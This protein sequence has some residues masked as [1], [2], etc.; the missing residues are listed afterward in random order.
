MSRTGAIFFSL[1]LCFLACPMR[2]QVQVVED[3]SKSMTSN[4]QTIDASNVTAKAPSVSVVGDTL[5]FSASV[6]RLAEDA[7]LED[8]L[9]KIPGIEVNGNVV[10][11]Y[12]KQIS[13]LRVN[14]KRYFG[15]DVASGLQ[16]LP[17]DMIDRVGAY[18]R[19]SD[20]ARLTGVDDGELVPVLDVK[21]KQDFLE[22][23]KGRLTAGGGDKMRYVVKANGNK[24]GE[25]EQSSVVANLHNLPGKASFNNASRTQ[26]GGGGSGESSRREAGYSYAMKSKDK[27]LDW[28]IRYEGRHSDVQSQVQTQNVN[29][30]TISYANANNSSFVINDS[31]KASMRYMWK[32][33]SQTTVVLKPAL[34]YQRTDTWTHNFADNFRSDPYGLDPDSKELIRASSADN[35][36]KGFTGRING[37]MSA[38]WTR[39]FKKRGR[40]LSFQ[41]DGSFMLQGLD[42]GT[43]YRT[44]YNRTKLPVDTTRRQYIDQDTKDWAFSLQAAWSEPVAKGLFLQFMVRGEYKDR[45]E[46]RRLYDITKADNFWEVLNTH[47]VSEFQASLPDD[48]SLCYQDAVSYMGRY[49]YYALV[50]NLNLRYAKKRFNV[51]AGLRV[52]PAMQEILWPQGGENK[53]IKTDVCYLAPNLTLNYNPTKRRKLTAS[54]RS[55]L[56]QP[57][58]YTLLPVSNGTNPL[59][60]HVGNPEVKPSNTHTFNIA[61]NASSF[62]RKSS[63]TGDV[64]LRLTENAVCNSTEYDEETGAKTITPRNIDGNWYAQGH[65]VL[66]K[67]FS[68][69]DFS[70][71]AHTSARYDNNCNYLYNKVARM[72]ETNIITRAMLKESLRTNYRNFWL[73]ITLDLGGD[74]TVEHSLL[75]PDLDQ[76]PWSLVASLSTAVSAPWGMRFTADYTRIMQR[77]F[78]YGDFN[79]SYDVLNGG[80][81]QSFLKKKLVV[82]LEACDILGQLPNL[83]RRYS[84]ESRSVSLFN[85]VNSYVLLRLIWKIN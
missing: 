7:S 22:N 21:I 67:A 49:R 57:S 6:Y 68:G 42:Q 2:A 59:S 3:P 36:L 29:I 64:Q 50:T 23:W 74:Y 84:A 78:A 18:E 16:N 38:L 10:T 43:N 27:E 61:Y 14:G 62:V 54:Y 12:G 37:S 83:V 24:I 58:I 39:R 33:D 55:A 13:E 15:G 34:S 4:T 40:S 46:S 66:T 53:R 31:P 20:F 5:V 1:V 65:L 81:S 35:R 41:T 8:L 28:N 25:K 19:E 30:S 82:R 75:R 45:S 63:I 26:L 77:G 79:N 60:V 80:I 70:V 52:T 11:L 32:P 56:G 9:R 76:S 17:A 48:L 44:M 47:S 85:G 72:D 69:T 73:D 71:S 51:T